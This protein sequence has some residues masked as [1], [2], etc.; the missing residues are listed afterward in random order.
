MASEFGKDVGKQGP[1]Q[2]SGACGAFL[3]V[4]SRFEL[5]FL[6]ESILWGILRTSTQ[7][8]VRRAQPDTGVH[9]GTIGGALLFEPETRSSLAA[10]EGVAV[11]GLYRCGDAAA[12][13]DGVHWGALREALQD[14]HL[15]GQHV[16]FMDGGDGALGFRLE[17]LGGVLDEGARGIS[18]A[19]LMAAG[20]SGS[21]PP[22][23]RFISIWMMSM[24]LISLV[25]SK[26]RLMRES[27][28]ARHTG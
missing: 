14:G 3:V 22:M 5:N 15:R 26:M 21:C 16:A 28:Y 19:S 12:Q 20:I 4:L 9:E 25:P 24:R 17:A 18:C 8:L 13:R 1:A 2:G 23:A 10:F 27:R 7:S 6:L 11:L